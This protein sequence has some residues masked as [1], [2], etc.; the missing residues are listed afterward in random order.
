MRNRVATFIFSAIIS[1]SAMAQN[2]DVQIINPLPTVDLTQFINAKDLCGA[3]EVFQV[4]LNPKGVPGFIKAFFSWRKIDQTN[5]EEVY[6]MTS[7]NFAIR[8]FYSNELCNS[9]ITVKQ[10]N[11]NTT[12][13]D[14]ALRKGVP[15]GS[16]R[17]TVELYNETGLLLGSD[18]ETRDFTN[19][20]AT[21]ALIAPIQLM[22]YDESSVPASWNPVVGAQSYKIRAVR[23]TSFPPSLES[24]IE[25]GTPCI[26]NVDVGPVTQLNDLSSL[27]TANPWRP[28]DFVVVRVTAIV[29]GAGANQ[30]LNSNIVLFQIRNANNPQASAIS[31]L[32]VN[33]LSFLPPN[34]V[35]PELIQFLTDFGASI[36]SYQGDGGQNLNV[37]ELLAILNAII[38]NPD[39]LSNIYIQQ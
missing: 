3:P 14:D 37:N 27:Q 29:P 18:T 36:S 7:N 11:S 23:L 28:G 13:M 5:Y 1:F 33:L 21:L 6:S 26:N 35:S 15:V 4:R 9:E 25:D 31:Q 22:S 16:Y 39:I 20:A 34:M 32:I 17:I 2:V 12:L 38:A 19:P 24:A 10:E 30:E 8:D